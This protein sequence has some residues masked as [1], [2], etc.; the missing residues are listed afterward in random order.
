MEKRE[1][2]DEQLLGGFLGEASRREVALEEGAVLAVEDAQRADPFPLDLL[3]VAVEE[4]E[5]EGLAKGFGRARGEGGEDFREVRAAPFRRDAREAEDEV[6][7]GAAGDDGGL[8]EGRGAFGEA[9]LRF[10]QQP[11]DAE[12]EDAVPVGRGVADVA[13]RLEKAPRPGLLVPLVRLR[14][15]GLAD[16][17]GAFVGDF[18]EGV[19][20]RG[21]LGAG[22]GGV[23]VARH[24]VA[25]DDAGEGVARA[26]GEA[27]VREGVG[28]HLRARHREG[29]AGLFA[30]LVDASHAGVDLLVRQAV[31]EDGVIKSCV[32]FGAQGFVQIVFHVHNPSNKRRPSHYRKIMRSPPE[33]ELKQPKSNRMPSGRGGPSR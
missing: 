14:E 24:V 31:R 9:A 21:A 7:Q 27:D 16:E 19:A 5:L 28:E 26:D 13:L 12:G 30:L 8:G 11:G 33:T 2:A 6:A 4:G 10:G 1:E 23:A 17:P 29:C 15:A 25:L 20:R 18:G 22:G 3:R 32:K